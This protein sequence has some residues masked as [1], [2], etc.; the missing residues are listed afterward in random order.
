MLAAYSVVRTAYMGLWALEVTLA[1]MFAAKAWRFITDK[2]GDDAVAP[3]GLVAREV[4]RIEA[5]QCRFGHELNETIDPFT[6]GLG[7]TVD[8]GHDFVGRAALEK[9]RDKAPA[10]RRVGV[11]LAR[12]ENISPAAGQ[13]APRLGD[14]LHAGD[15]RR[16]GS[17]TS[18][19]FSPKLQRPI[20]MAYIEAGAARSGGELTVETTAGAVESAIVDPPFVNP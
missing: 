3:A 18:G 5:G 7:H 1:N 4:L 16:I 20:A 13:A 14:V 6:A 17:V 12:P 15:G 9:L 10:R 2:A 19:T 11:V 8:F